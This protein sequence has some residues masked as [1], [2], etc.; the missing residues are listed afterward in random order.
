MKPYIISRGG[1][2]GQ[3]IQDKIFNISLRMRNSIG[4]DTKQRRTKQRITKQ[5]NCKIAKTNS[6]YTKQ[7]KLQNSK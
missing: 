4:M 3:Y 1:W 6:E 5:R 7:R 2:V